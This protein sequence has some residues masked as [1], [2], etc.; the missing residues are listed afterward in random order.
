MPLLLRLLPLLYLLPLQAEEAA[1]VVPPAATPPPATA[2]CRVLHAAPRQPPVTVFIDGAEHVS[3]LAYGAL[4]P[5]E[6]LPGGV[7]QFSLTLGEAEV[8]T[9]QDATFQAGNDYTVAVVARPAGLQF[10]LLR[11]REPSPDDESGRVRAT[12]LVAGRD[13]TFGVDERLLGALLA[14]GQST[15]A[16][17]V[18]VGDRTYRFAD[19]TP[20]GAS[21][22]VGPAS[23]PPRTTYNLYLLGQAGATDEAAVRVLE[24]LQDWPADTSAPGVA[25]S[26]EHLP[27][28]RL[29]VL[30][31]AGATGAL[32]G[33]LDDKPLFANLAFGDL[34]AYLPQTSGQH[35]FE[36]VGAATID[37]T[38]LSLDEHEAYTLVLCGEPDRLRWWLLRDAAE[39]VARPS[40]RIAHAAWQAPS[41]ELSRLEGERLAKALPYFGLTDYLAV[42]DLLSGQRLAVALRPEGQ[43]TV[44]QAAR[45]TLAADGQY[46]LF[47]ADSGTGDPRTV[48]LKLVRDGG[49]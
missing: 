4:S 40:L 36:L 32:A 48:R 19:T 18:P 33:R 37:G 46:T 10:L 8:I 28:T 29:R 16:I 42:G 14:P 9:A 45:L 7:H 2:R 49:P 21:L 38:A 35:R 23:V 11:D 47:L 43:S 25:S 15:P 5:Y 27:A 41:L 1:P 22:A 24:D 30:H 20:G 26:V 6:A 44:V 39:T 17:P 34:T 3:A 12:N 13:F 31:L